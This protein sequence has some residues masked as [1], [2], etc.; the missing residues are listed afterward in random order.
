MTRLRELE[1][2]DVQAINRWRQ[3][4][5]ITAGLGAPHRHIGIEVDERWF[6]TYLQRRG[7]DVR[8]AICNDEEREPIGVVSLTGV[9][10]VHKRAELHIMLGDR[11]SHGQGIGTE[12]TR[13]M[14]SHGFRDLNLHR[15]F[16][17]VLDSNAVARRMYEKAGFRHEGTLR[18][19]AF[20]NGRYEDVHVMGLLASEFAP[21]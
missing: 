13:A 17:F 21:A 3:D 7:T 1:R 8:C 2:G 20:K 9:D 14:L 5:Q 19:A 18:D 12:A 15:I 16:L 6:E 4:R 11:A 10:P